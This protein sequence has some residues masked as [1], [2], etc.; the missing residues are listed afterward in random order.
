MTVNA[1]MLN[2]P[3]LMEVADAVA[4][5]FIVGSILMVAGRA[6]PPTQRLKP[7]SR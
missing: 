4:F 3:P 5:A 1:I 7:P 2:A 6:A